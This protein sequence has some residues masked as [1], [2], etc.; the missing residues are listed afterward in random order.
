MLLVGGRPSSGELARMRSAK[1]RIPRLG[2]TDL[3]KHE[4]PGAAVVHAIIEARGDKQAF[5]L[6]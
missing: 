4:P 5:A 2:A 3:L 6:V 1:T